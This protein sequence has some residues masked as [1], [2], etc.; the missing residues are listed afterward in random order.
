MIDSVDKS[1]Y[2]ALSRLHG[3]HKTNFVIDMLMK[4][5]QSNLFHRLV[6][7][8]CIKHKSGEQSLYEHTAGPANTRIGRAYRLMT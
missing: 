5:L 7:K 4:H 8:G 3:L 1:C 2:I 6:N